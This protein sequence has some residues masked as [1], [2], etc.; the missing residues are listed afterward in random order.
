[1]TSNEAMTAGTIGA[2]SLTENEDNQGN[3][4]AAIRKKSKT[5]AM[6]SKFLIRG[7]KRSPAKE[8]EAQA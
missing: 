2:E 4:A 1:M 6:K 5:S 7:H 8:S 3:T